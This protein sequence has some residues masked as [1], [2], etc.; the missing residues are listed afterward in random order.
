MSVLEALTILAAGVAAG[1]INTV[2]GSGTLITFPVL[3]GL[4][5]APLV[6][7][8][9]N[10]VG[11]VPGSL[12]G[13]LGYRGELAGQRGRML[14][15]GAA[16]VMGGAT[17]ALLL[18]VLPASAF[19]AIVPVFIV[20]A[21]VA[22]LAQPRL[23][24]RRAS[25]PR[26]AAVVGD[27]GPLAV[28]A[29]YASGV[30]GGYF[31][32]AQGILLLAIL[33]LAVPDDLQR[34]NALKIVLALLVNVVSGLIFVAVADVAWRPAALI[35]AGSVLGGAIAARYGRRLPA[36]ALRALIVV[37]GLAAIGRLVT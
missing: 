3:L 12:A 8:V 5:Y 16:S 28:A 4:G 29:V 9:S 14:R 35:A 30:Y 37:V 33:G 20:I 27:G 15:L 21:L 11:L 25:R 24:R 36:R 1:A 23:S 10:T 31:G 34:S 13:A 2:V 26:R 7:N 19:R 22:I 18:L 6:A 17:G 32:A